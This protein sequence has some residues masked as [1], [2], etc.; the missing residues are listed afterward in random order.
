[1]KGVTGV[2]PEKFDARGNEALGGAAFRERLLFSAP[3]V[4]RGEKLIMNADVFF[5]GRVSEVRIRKARFWGFISGS[6]SGEIWRK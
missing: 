6:L 4:L 2:C 1:M 3:A 5:L